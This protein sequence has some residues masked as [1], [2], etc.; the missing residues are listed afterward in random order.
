MSADIYRTVR[1]ST[2]LVLPRGAS[3]ANVPREALAGLGVPQFLSSRDLGD[4]L[5]SVNTAGV[6]LDLTA[7][8]YAIREV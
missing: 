3:L 5:L 7:Q 6:R 1:K 2:F 8:G 4:P